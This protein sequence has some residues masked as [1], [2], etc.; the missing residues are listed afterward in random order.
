MGP[1]VSNRAALPCIMFPVRGWAPDTVRAVFRAREVVVTGCE[2]E[3]LPADFRI[4]L[5]SA[6]RP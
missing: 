5:F 6:G 2:L 3:A 4:A 1:P